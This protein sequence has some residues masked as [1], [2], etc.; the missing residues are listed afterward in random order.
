M[1]LSIVQTVLQCQSY[2]KHVLVHAA[3][4]KK[5]FSTHRGT[6]RLNK[7]A[8]IERATS[9]APLLFSSL[10][11]K[12]DDLADAFLL[13]WYRWHHLRFRITPK[14]PQVY[15]RRESIR[16]NDRKRILPL[17]P[18]AGSADAE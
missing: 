8:A 6:H 10:S 17:S 9:L 14:I 12:V 7:L 1:C 13:A 4:I 11:G 15:G 3:T 2:K 18:D 5:V 16:E